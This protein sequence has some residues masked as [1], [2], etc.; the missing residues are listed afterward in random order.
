MAFRRKGSRGNELWRS[1]GTTA[2]TKL[3]RDIKPGAKGSGT[4]N[5]TNVGGTL[6]FDADD[7]RHGT[8]LWKA[9]P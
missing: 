4:R 1:D 7:G 5:L 6:F 8:E 9:V 2:G 3:V